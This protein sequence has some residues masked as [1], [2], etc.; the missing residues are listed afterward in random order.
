MPLSSPSLAELRA[1]AT[2]LGFSLSD[3]E[4]E[5]QRG[6][7]A[8]ALQGFGA[9]DS[10]DDTL[11]AVR[12]PRDG[13]RK[14]TP[15]ENPLGAWQVRAEI[16]GAEAGPLAG[17]SVAV[18]D[19]VMVAGLPIENG[20]PFFEGY[21]PPLDATVVTRILD[22]GGTITGKSVC[23]F[24]CFSGGSHTSYPGAVRNPHNHDHVAGGSSSGSAALVAAGEVDMA[25]GGDQGGSI[26]IPASAC[27]IVGMK[28]THGLVPYTGALPLM[29][30]VDH[31]G[32]MTTNVED[33]ALLLEVLAGPDGYDERQ[34][35]AQVKSYRQGLEAGVD[36]L[37]VGVLGEAFGVEGQM[38][39]VEAKVRGAADA[40]A[41]LG[42]SVKVVSAPLHPLSGAIAFGTMQ[43]LMVD[44]FHGGGFGFSSTDLQVPSFVERTRT[45][46]DHADQFPA[47]VKSLLLLTEVVRRQ[48]GFRYLAKARNLRRELRAD[49]DRLLGE[50]DVLLLPTAPVTAP[51]IPRDG[52]TA[53]EVYHAAYAMLAHTFAFNL[54][55]HPALSVPCGLVNGL[56]VG[57]MLVGRHWDE[58]T[59][60]RAAY[61]FQE[62]R[63]W[64]TR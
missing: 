34:H 5:D 8:A 6:V 27:G 26:R 40:L 9:L 48:A 45:L 46:W 32:P 62:D 57:L 15:E 37:R 58:P 2:H 13:G 4:L 18:K 25:V 56:P 50:L 63:D 7:V 23:E 21:R 51:R 10:A 19:N 11:P 29:A 3:E 1:A 30:D 16:R 33:N 44:A 59:L 31:L 41:D 47:N 35:S 53:A 24:F 22:A 54:T 60:Y 28:P 64:R 39:E 12:Y 14:P 36:G 17:R 43:A 38:P 61:A 49:Y 42:A 20:T 55:Q 52:A